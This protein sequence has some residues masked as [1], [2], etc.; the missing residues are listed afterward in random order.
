MNNLA[1]LYRREGKLRDAENLFTQ[2]V[3]LR[4]RLLGPDHPNTASVLTS[5]AGIKLAQ[6]QYDEAEV[7][8]RQALNG[9]EKS[10]ADT[11]LR[12]YAQSMLGASL[13]GRGNHAEAE[14]LLR[15][16]YQGMFQ[17]QS[18]IP[19]ENRSALDEVKG[20]LD[21]LPRL[22]PTGPIPR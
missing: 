4:R 10:S 8:L 21:V 9:Y 6:H 18:S 2:V 3:D 1:E 17:R 14:P 20:W 22:P 11:W 5:L 12:Y 19:A 7:L 15:S 13:A 16:G